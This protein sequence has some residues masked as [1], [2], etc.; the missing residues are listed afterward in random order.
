MVCFF[1]DIENYHDTG[2]LETNHGTNL[3]IFYSI[4]MI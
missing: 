1:I 4:T 2:K 3:E